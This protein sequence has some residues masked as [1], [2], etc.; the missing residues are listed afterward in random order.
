MTESRSYAG[1][2][3]MRHTSGEAGIDGIW[4][5]VFSEWQPR[6]LPMLEAMRVGLSGAGMEVRVDTLGPP[7]LEIQMLRVL[8]PYRSVE[9]SEHW[10]LRRVKPYDHDA[11]WAGGVFSLLH[12][13]WRDYPLFTGA[14][15]EI[16]EVEVRLMSHTQPPS[17]RYPGARFGVVGG[18]A[19]GLFCYARTAIEVVR[20]LPGVHVVGREPDGDPRQWLA[21]DVGHDKDGVEELAGLG[22]GLNALGFSTC[23]YEWRDGESSILAIDAGEL[24]REELEQRIEERMPSPRPAWAR[25]YR[26]WSWATGVWIHRYRASEGWRLREWLERELGLPVVD[27][28]HLA[29]DIVLKVPPAQVDR[30]LQ[31][32]SQRL[33]KS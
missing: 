32:L 31:L 24:S 17:P 1:R 15:S 20:H 16:E 18:R 33:A 6:R 14:E 19:W 11:D 26:P 25:R 3:G 13:R 12:Q 7:D 21:L 9:A 2:L 5:P 4:L 27:G 22:K 10:L 29:S 28:M 8:C 30:S 23:R